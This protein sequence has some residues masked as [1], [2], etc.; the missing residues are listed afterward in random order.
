VFAHK[1]YV[2]MYLQNNIFFSRRL[3]GVEKFYLFRCSN[4]A[5]SLVLLSRESDQLREFQCRRTRF[6]VTQFGKLQTSSLFVHRRMGLFLTRKNSF[7]SGNESS[8]KSKLQVFFAHWWLGLF[9][10]R[11]EVVD[12]SEKSELQGHLHIKVHDFSE[13]WKVR[14]NSLILWIFTRMS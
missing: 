12:R 8:E 7:E 10:H 4:P 2:Y 11:I 1:T 13:V 9:L 14:R 6:C 3:I 5:F